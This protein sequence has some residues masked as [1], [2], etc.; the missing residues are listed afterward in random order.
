MRNRGRGCEL[1]R[2]WGYAVS[3]CGEGVRVR[4]RDPIGR[5]FNREFY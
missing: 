5:F 3:E 1:V 4:F 2:V